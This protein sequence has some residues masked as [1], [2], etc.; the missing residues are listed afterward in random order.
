MCPCSLLLTLT[1]FNNVLEFPMGEISGWF[2]F[3]LAKFHQKELAVSKKLF[4]ENHFCLSE[5]FFFFT[6]VW[7]RSLIFLEQGIQNCQ[8]HFLCRWCAFACSQD[9][10]SPLFGQ[11]VR[12]FRKCNYF[13]L[14]WIKN[15]WWRLELA[16]PRSL[17]GANCG[18]NRL[19]KLRSEK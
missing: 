8:G 2:Y 3:F 9:K 1:N 11:G 13:M 10:Q 15:K 14:S 6:A 17:V 5:T 7:L 19:G 16:Q 4:L 18:A 12:V